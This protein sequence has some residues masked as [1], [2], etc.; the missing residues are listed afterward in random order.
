MVTEAELLSMALIK[1]KLTYVMGIAR[2]FGSKQNKI[3]KKKLFLFPDLQ[4]TVDDSMVV[5]YIKIM[6]SNLPSKFTTKLKK[7]KR[8]QKIIII[9]DK[10]E[11]T[12]TC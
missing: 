4:E 11:L 8:M 2:N 3:Q 1:I 9:L 5:E 10:T 7:Q 6:Q 12:M